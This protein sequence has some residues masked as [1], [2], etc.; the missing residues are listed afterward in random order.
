M[1]QYMALMHTEGIALTFTDDAI[2]RIADFAT[3][4]NDRTENIGARRLHTALEKLLDEISRE[5]P[6]REEKTVTVDEACVTRMLADIV[7][8]GDL[9]RCSLWP[10]PAKREPF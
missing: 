5:G 10:E 9:S 7:K 3:T 1:K 6:D 4:V 8:N 2:R